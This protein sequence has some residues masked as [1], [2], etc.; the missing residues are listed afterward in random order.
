MGD[1]RDDKGRHRMLPLSPRAHMLPGREIPDLILPYMVH[2]YIQG[3]E[4]CSDYMVSVHY[5]DEGMIAA[6][7]GKMIFFRLLSSLITLPKFQQAK[8]FTLHCALLL[9]VLIYSFIAGMIF[10][11]LESEHLENKREMEW[12]KKLLCVHQV[13]DNAT[14][15]T[16]RNYKPINST[17]EEI[18]HCFDAKMDAKSTWSPLTAAFYGF[19]IATTLGYNYLHPETIA[20]RMFCIVYGICSIPV[21]MIIVANV[22]QYLHQFAG[23]MKKNIEV[24]NKR[25]RAS[26]AHLTEDDIP[27]ASVTVASLGLL[28]FFLL[29]VSLGALFLPLLNGEMDFWNGL[30]VNF[31]CL[32]A[33]DGFGHLVPKK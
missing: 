9:V 26:K 32:T 19:G 11:W 10:R 28:L 6:V 33:I 30:Y 31:I 20:G 17:L 3:R 21:T 12:Q 5:V 2:P 16:Y 8:P 13:F 4:C 7:C 14:A 1:S 22:G 29:Y 18:I 15:L 25:R 24:R 23:S 27:D